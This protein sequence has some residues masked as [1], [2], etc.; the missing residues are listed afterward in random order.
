MINVQIDKKVGI[1]M[2]ISLIIGL[3][4]GGAMGA[5]AGHH[6]RDG[7]DGRAGMMQGRFNQQ[8]TR[9]GWGMMGRAQDATIPAPGTSPTQQGATAPAQ[10][11]PTPVTK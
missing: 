10:P 7:F 3:V 8:D 4:V 11:T 1:L 2:G 6:D 5:L 9:G